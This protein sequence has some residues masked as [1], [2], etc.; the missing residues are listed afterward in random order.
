[1]SQAGWSLCWLLPLEDK[2]SVAADAAGEPALQHQGTG[3][4]RVL[5]SSQPHSPSFG[6]E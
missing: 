6:L 2:G 4:P 3:G 5:L 1:M